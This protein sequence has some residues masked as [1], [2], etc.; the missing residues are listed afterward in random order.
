MPKFLVFI[1]L[2]LSSFSKVSACGYSPYGEDV[3][4]CLLQP[5][6][7]NYTSYSPFN[8]NASLWGFN[9]EYS[10]ESIEA[11]ILDWHN[12]T[13]KKAPIYAIQEFN[14]K[15]KVTDIH[16]NSTNEFIRYLYANKKTDAIA[17]LKMAKECEVVNSLNV[18]DPWERNQLSINTN[19][20]TFLN[21]LVRITNEQKNEY[22]K[23]KYA[24]LTIRLAFY[25]NDV[26]LIKKIF[27]TNY[28]D[29]QKDYL[30]YWSL[31]FYSFA[32]DDKSFMMDAANLMAN[33]PEKFYA[34][35]YF[36]HD[37]FKLEEALSFAKT[38]TEI[39]NLYAYASVQR[40]DRN[41]DYLKK[42][43]KNQPN[44]KILSFLLLREI[45]KLEDW[46]YTPYYTNYNPSTNFWKENTT[47][48]T[49]RMRSENDR[50]YAKEVLQFLQSIDLNKTENPMLWKAAK[51]Q[52]EFMS[53]DFASCLQS[54][55]Q[56]EKQFSKEEAVFGQVQL[57]KALVI[58]ANQEFGKAII[59]PEIH[60]IILKN[61]SDSR[62][63]FALGRELEF[64]GNI[65]DGMALMA[66]L[67]QISNEVEWQGNRSVTSGNLNEFYTYF[68]YLDFVYSANDLQKIANRLKKPMKSDFEREIYSV[69]LRDQLQILD[70]LGTKYIRED[71][72]GNALAI[73][74]SMDK[75]YWEDNY[76]PWERGNYNE[77]Y[78]FDQ[79]PFFTF[80]NTG[81]F[82]KPREKFNVNKLTITEHLIKYLK[83]ANNP[84]TKNKDYYYFIIANCYHNMSQYGH[85]WMLRRFQ[86]YT[87]W[88]YGTNEYMNE[89]YIDEYEYRA[90]KKALQYYDLA[91]QNAKTNKFKA[92]CLR[93][94]DYAEHQTYSSS[95]RVDKVYPQYAKELS[96]CEN[97]EDFFKSRR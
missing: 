82:I 40:L 97:L 6:L 84:Q 7:F 41:L 19:R 29:S 78:A 9:F 66:S 13:N 18:E 5:H 96:G 91:Y 20:K 76:N 8:Y 69:L 42:I 14:Y 61:K 3:R 57:I 72:L 50:L 68:D 55:R 64:K 62:F 51:I 35:Y 11:N 87:Y 21:K 22:F 71:K 92:L 43:H 81:E 86:S 83:I 79:N 95:K 65:Q 94:M 28:T 45:N 73:F 10:T 77:Y 1:V 89:S 85:S 74:K 4:Y 59:Q 30:Y 12:Y 56:F 46:I 75:K 88:G 24:F 39:A 53:R 34:S 15:L 90:N 16:S 44:S 67:D 60:S 80:K 63:L 26:E 2:L 47:T 17:Y 70:L 93:M 23:R 33:C 58:T 25:A 32:K 36:H 54:I 48:Q 52:V 38:K 49:L 27:T 37:N 31:F